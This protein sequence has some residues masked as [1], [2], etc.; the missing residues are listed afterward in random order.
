M[1][2]T[3][4]HLLS[5]FARSIVKKY[6]PVVVGIT[7]SVG[8]TSSKEAISLIL[9]CQKRVRS[10]FSNYNNEFGL[11]LTIIGLKSPGKNLFKWVKVFVFATNLLLFKDK[12]YPEILVLEMGVDREGDMDYLLKIVKPDRAVLTNISHSHLEYFGSI[13]KIKKE[14]VKLLQGLKKGGVAIINLDNDFSK[15]IKDNLKNLVISYGINSEADVLARDI[16]FVLPENG[17][18]NNFYGINFKLEY[19]GS[20][21]PV[22][23]SGVISISSVYAILSAVSVAISLEFNIIDL[24]NC[25]KNFK[26]PTG[27]M[28]ILPGVKNTIIIDDT[29]NSSPES[30]LIALDFLEKIKKTK[31]SRRIVVLGDMLELGNYSED[32]HRLVGEKVAKIGVDE[33]ILV[34]ERA[35]DIGRGA[36]D[37]KFNKELIFHFTN[38]EDAGLFL[39]DRISEN[40]VV[41]IKG[42]Q[43]VRLEKVVKEIMA[44]PEKAGELLVRQT[45]EWLKK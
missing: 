30:S 42:S 33:I 20:V 41:L 21:V 25:L 13:E 27:R 15:D 32:G 17:V 26:N 1:K 31:N 12:N 16:N 40:D 5:F 11:P 43:G 23:L 38:P 36:I 24:I 35:R 6:N 19:K 14:K 2:K 7:G 39:Q 8:K 29:Y 45:D 44:E 18:K 10:N 9:S 4:I 3:I 37:N 28:N 34:G 22:S